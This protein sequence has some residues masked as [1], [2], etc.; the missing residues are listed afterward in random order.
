[1]KKKISIGQLLIT[2]FM[3]MYEIGSSKAKKKIELYLIISII[4]YIATLIITFSI[5]IVF[6]IIW[7]ALSISVLTVPFIKT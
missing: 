2:W 7:L 3:L 5:F 4:S 6:G 1:M